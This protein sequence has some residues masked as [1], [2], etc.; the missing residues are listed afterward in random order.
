MRISIFF[1]RNLNW[2]GVGRE[3]VNRK[4]LFRIKRGSACSGIANLRLVLRTKPRERITCGEMVFAVA[5]KRVKRLERVKRI[6]RVKR[7]NVI[8]VY[9]TLWVVANTERR[10][11]LPVVK[12]FARQEGTRGCK[13]LIANHK[14]SKP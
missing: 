11:G 3:A 6:M 12:L 7:M 10:K 8:Y 4:I 5:R 14:C 9:Q 1:L 2:F 13:A